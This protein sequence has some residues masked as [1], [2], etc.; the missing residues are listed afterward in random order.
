MGA[1]CFCAVGGTTFAGGAGATFGGAG[2]AG[3][4]GASGSGGVGE[5]SRGGTVVAGAEGP[6][7]TA[8]GTEAG[9]GAGTGAGWAETAGKPVTRNRNTRTVGR[10]GI[11]RFL[12]TATGPKVTRLPGTRAATNRRFAPVAFGACGRAVLVNAI[13][14]PAWRTLTMITAT[15]RNQVQ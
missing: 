6:E 15:A 4:T 14:G 12:Y 10:L 8:G 9:A 13:P 11:E 5:A 3:A 1:C 2:G 7:V